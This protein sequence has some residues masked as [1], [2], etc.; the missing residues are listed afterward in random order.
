MSP[1]LPHRRNSLKPFSRTRLRIEPLE[2][3]DVPATFTVSTLSD[4]GNDLAPTPGSLRAAIE[5]ADAA[6]GADTITFASGLTG[7]IFLQSQLDLSSDV[8]ITGPGAEVITV[9]GL[10]Y[11]GATPGFQN[12]VL[13]ITNNATVSIAGLTIADGESDT[14]DI[15]PPGQ[16]AG[17]GGGIFI[18]QS[19]LTLDSVVF[20]NNIATF[21][22]GA[23]TGQ[24]ANITIS[25]SQ[26]LGNR[27][28]NFGSGGAISFVSGQ[29]LVSTSEFRNNSGANGGAITVQSST[30]AN[31]IERSLFV[32]NSASYGGSAIETNGAI[33]SLSIVNNTFTQNNAGSGPGVIEI[34]S[35]YGGGIV[36]QVSLI[37]NTISGNT[38][39]TG[40]G[41][42]IYASDDT[43][44]GAL[45]PVLTLRN[46]ISFGNTGSDVEGPAGT[47]VS[48]GGNVFGVI[49]GTISGNTA[50][51]LVGVDPQLGPLQDN[52]GPTL[53][54]A[55][56]ASSPAARVGI[57]GGTTPTVD[58]RGV[59]RPA[60]GPIDAGAFQ[61]LPPTPIPAP[62]IV[63]VG[64]GAGVP[65]LIRT[66]NPDG[67]PAGSFAPFEPTF[68]GG[69]RVAIGDV[70]GDGVADTI[71]AAGP[72]GSPRVVVFDGKTNTEL[73]SFF[74]YEDSFVG[75][76]FV[77]AGDV[78][79][80]GLAD[81]VTGPGS[82]GG[83]RIRVFSLDSSTGLFNPAVGDFFA[84][85]DDPNY[86]GGA[87][88]AV[89]DMDGD[90]VADII[91]TPGPG[92]GPRVQ[93]YSVNNGTATSIASFFVDGIEQTFRGGL[94]VAAYPAVGN[95]PATLVFG[96]DNFPGAA[97]SV[98]ADIT[99][100]FL[101]ADFISAPNLYVF[102]VPSNGS[103]GLSLVPVTTT[104][105][106]GPTFPEGIRVGTFTTTDGFP[107]IAA[108]SG[109]GGNGLVQFYKLSGNT[110]TPLFAD[111]ISAFDPAAVTVPG[112]TTST[113]AYVGGSTA[114]TG[115]SGASTSG[116]T[117]G[118]SEGELITEGTPPGMIGA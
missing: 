83:P 90:G 49:S 38:A 21:G 71:A 46:N 80:D 27:T 72:G 79:G 86:S 103:G 32:G 9:S 68:L 14:S 104:Q 117:A 116:S 66:F 40:Y 62:S 3:R 111:P 24:T 84:F 76:V 17:A 16:F 93:I 23:I 109:E 34:D 77:A 69:V 115:S 92:G 53:T 70:N 5:A 64:T 26:F 20:Q 102:S 54:M 51:D 85:S 45:L 78:T 99:Q 88:V 63:A 74:A 108:S 56:S 29:L 1:M 67:T 44:G 87:R 11:A 50:A 55:I 13:A 47:L 10:A 6:P 52:G 96:P 89:G 15:V 19:N 37:N 4:N 8:T 95:Q 81:I 82:S 59:A 42:G 33:T 100:G 61:T 57:I 35:D 31:V 113:S 112:S 18:S 75:G 36:P 118:E 60:G 91:V 2:Q 43:Y 98:L 48:E 22:G 25:N 30:A 101:A 28:G 12:R 107:G 105:P 114:G 110:L 97:Q 73:A 7:T 41:G 106:F 94:F 65:S 39:A 58:Q